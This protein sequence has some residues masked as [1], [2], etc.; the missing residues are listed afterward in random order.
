MNRNVFVSKTISLKFP[1]K[2]KNKVV[3]RVPK[4]ISMIMKQNKRWIRCK[5]AKNEKT[6]SL[7]GFFSVTFDSSILFYRRKK[8]ILRNFGATPSSCTARDLCEAPLLGQVTSG[9][10]VRVHSNTARSGV[11]HTT[12]SG[13]HQVILWVA[14][15]PSLLVI[16]RKMRPPPLA[17]RFF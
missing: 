15:P 8:R 4:L 2:R 11:T 1:E 12:R 6:K 16:E 9:Q 13:Q 14:S 7:V 17:S 3:S 10:K 5:E